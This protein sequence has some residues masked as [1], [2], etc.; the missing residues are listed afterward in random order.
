MKIGEGSSAC[1]FYP[2]L[3]CQGEPADKTKIGKLM[4]DNDQVQKEVRYARLL[5]KLDPGR[6]MLYYVDPEE[7][8]MQRHEALAE[9]KKQNESCAVTKNATFHMFQ[10]TMPYGGITFDKYLKKVYGY[11]KA[12]RID[13]IRELEPVFL[14]IQKMTHAKLVHQDIKMPNI[15]G[16]PRTKQVRL[17]DFGLTLTHDEFY[18]YNISFG[19]KYPY[20]GP[21]Y[22]LLYVEDLSA[23]HEVV[24]M[25]RSMLALAINLIKHS[26]ASNTDY[27]K[28]YGIGY[29]TNTPY[30]KKNTASIFSLLA[31]LKNG[32]NHKQ[33]LAKMKAA[34][35]ASKADMWGLGMLLLQASPYLVSAA[36]D[37]P[38]SVSI[39]ADLIRGMLMPNP[40]DRITIDNA[41]SR[42]KQME[43]LT[44]R[45]RETAHAKSQSTSALSSSWT[46]SASASKSKSLIT[47]TKASTKPRN[48]SA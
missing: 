25:E 26:K 1:A 19:H 8:T 35:Y 3:P 38:K 48:R 12:S 47:K 27:Y 32:T 41:V 10:L 21:E 36:D 40:E 34:N 15:V 29:D 23:I 18:K 20:N 43:K 45:L 2:S 24:D 14:G 42:I 4:A 22:R 28:E 13:V 31:F 5:Q 46:P 6:K 17:I 33:R 44:Y 7:C 11:G 39:Y 16:M 37:N 9:L 30:G